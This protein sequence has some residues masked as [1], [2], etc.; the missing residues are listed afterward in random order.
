MRYRTSPLPRSATDS[1]SAVAEPPHQLS[2]T[3]GLA[4]GVGQTKTGGRAEERAGT[5]FPEEHDGQ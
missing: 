3:A 4:G 5:T 1:L 2:A